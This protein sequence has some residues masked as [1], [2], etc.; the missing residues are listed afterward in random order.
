MST[1]QRRMR[2]AKW[3]KES[4]RGFLLTRYKTIRQRV[5]GVR[6]NKAHLYKG[7]PLCDKEEFI[8]WSLKDEAF[9]ELH[10]QWL[11]SGCSLKATP[12][13]T[14]VEGEDGFVVGNMEWTNYSMSSSLSSITKFANKKLKDRMSLNEKV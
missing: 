9:K 12:S 10:K 14:R 2:E 11:E 4:P 8:R 13:V 3:R 7:L 1:S 5:T 6:K